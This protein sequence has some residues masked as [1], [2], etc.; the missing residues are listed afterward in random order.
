[1]YPAPARP[2]LRDDAR[3]ATGRGPAATGRRIVDTL[4]LP[5]CHRKTDP[6]RFRLTWWACQSCG[7]M[8]APVLLADAAP[9]DWGQLGAPTCP[10]RS[11]VRQT[12]LSAAFRIAILRPMRLRRS[13]PSSVLVLALSGCSAGGSVSS[14]DAGAPTVAQ[15]AAPSQATVPAA[16]ATGQAL[17]W[18]SG[19]YDFK[20]QVL[21][22]RINGMLLR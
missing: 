20:D 2:A 11:V 19:T 7:N 17:S 8:R 15:E 21:Q 18:W 6:R 1:L 10:G 12:T 5:V 13:V 14:A 3:A 4:R 22:L 16:S 9:K